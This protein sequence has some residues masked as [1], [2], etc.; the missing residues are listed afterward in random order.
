M[1]NSFEKKCIHF[2]KYFLILPLFIDNCYVFSC[3][4][5]SLILQSMMPGILFAYRLLHINK[6]DDTK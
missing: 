5:F 3:N 1:L 6:T 4:Y 2:L